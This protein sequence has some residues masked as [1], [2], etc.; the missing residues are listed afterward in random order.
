MNLMKKMESKGKT[1]KTVLYT[2]GILIGVFLP[3]ILKLVGSTTFLATEMIIFA[4]FAIGFNLL[5]GFTGI[6]S[7]GH[8]A[9]L[10]VASYSCALFQLNFTQNSVLLPM[11]FGIIFTTLVGAIIGKLIIK[12]RGIYFAYVTIAVGQLIFFIVFRW[13]AL[14]GGE[15]GLGGIK[16]VPLLKFINIQPEYN[17][18]IFVFII[19]LI[20]LILMKIIV[21]S[22]FGKVLQA[23][24][25]NRTRAIFVGYDVKSYEL[26]AFIISVFYASVAGSLYAFLLNYV[27]PESLHWTASGEVVIMT[28]IGGM[29]YLFGPVIGA[30]IVTF[31]KDFISSYT[32]RWQI[33]LGVIFV[34][35]VL[36]SPEGILGF[37]GN[38]KARN[39]FRLKKKVKKESKS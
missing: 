39:P 26:A 25:E 31:L 36:G 12:T 35:F 33:V 29:H 10:G 4:I 19:F 18:Y 1:G 16:R 34:V 8:A 24:R 9:W 5:I 6:L 13:T 38:K 3:F 21:N 37:F 2:V 17:F 11:L 30:F 14:T 27:F 22:P 15:N 7:F 20:V 28:L 23:I 32:D